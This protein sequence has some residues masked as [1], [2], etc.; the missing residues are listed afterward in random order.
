MRP[1]LVV[2]GNRTGVDV[3][4]GKAAYALLA[5]LSCVSLLPRCHS[6]GEGELFSKGL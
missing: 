2:T 1:V 6:Q 4:M 5:T 3:I